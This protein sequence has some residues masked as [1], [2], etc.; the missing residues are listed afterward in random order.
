MKYQIILP[1]RI[2]KGLNK[3]EKRH[4]E[5]I[6]SALEALSEDPYLGKKLSGKFKNCYSF[7]VWSY[8]VIYQIK[9]KQ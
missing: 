2:E 7:R 9:K 5:K 1:K 4:Y 6:L 8:R 3:I